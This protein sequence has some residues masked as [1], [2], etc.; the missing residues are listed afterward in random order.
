MFPLSIH[1]ETMTSSESR[2]YAPIKGRVFGSESLFHMITSRQNLCREPQ[3]PPCA[4]SI[5]RQTSFNFPSCVIFTD[6][7]LIATVISA[8]LPFHT[9]PNPPRHSGSSDR[10]SS[11]GFSAY[12]VGRTPRAAQ[13]LHSDLKHLFWS[14]FITSP[15]SKYCGSERW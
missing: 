14:T 8:Y 10:C 4:G 15:V 12:C 6:N 9:A 2:M 5:N 1:S 11:L 7:F 13:I 3:P